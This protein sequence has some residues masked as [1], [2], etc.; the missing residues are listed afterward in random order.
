M[1]CM[2]FTCI[3]Y[4]NI[5]LDGRYWDFKYLANDISFRGSKLK[6]FADDKINSPQKLKFVLGMVE[7]TVRKGKNAG[8]QHFL[9]FPQWFQKASFSRSLEVELCSK[10]LNYL[11]LEE[12]LG[13]F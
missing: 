4:T 12:H 11:G 9:L 10:E 1:V 5:I 2:G 7:N 8:Y 6:A 13:F 3:L